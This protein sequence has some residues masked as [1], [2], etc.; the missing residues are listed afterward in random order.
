VRRAAWRVG[1]ALIDQLFV[2]DTYW[3]IIVKYQEKSN[4]TT[5]L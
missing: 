5:D 2:V 3:G 4:K 1:K